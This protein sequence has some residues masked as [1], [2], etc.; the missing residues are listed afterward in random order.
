MTGLARKP[1]A[2]PQLEDGHVRIANELYD[3]IFAFGFKA[4]TLHVLMIVIRKT[5]GYGKKEDDVSASQIGDMCGMKRPHVTAA[6]NE[7]SAMGVIHKRPGKYGAIVGINKN[8]QAWNKVSDST[9]SVQVEVG[10][11]STKTVHPYESRTSTDSVQVYENG[12]SGS[13]KSVQVDSTKFVHTKDN[14]PKDNQQKKETAGAVSSCAELN[15]TP[16]A[17]PPVAT[18]PLADGSEHP[19]T[20][21]MAAEWSAAYPAVDVPSELLRMRAWL[22]ANTANRKTRRG[23]SRF[24]VSWLSR[25]QDRAPVQTRSASRPT[26]A[27][28]RRHEWNQRLS[29]ALGRT[30]EP[31]AV[32]DLGVFDATT[33]KPI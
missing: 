30:N 1:A 19:I 13:T 6:L 23:V 15:S 25:S 3:A 24:V 32:H 21:A 31:N 9:K 28:D 4:S 12:T 10:K 27:A 33:G 2:S 14:L 20:E 17:P 18:L 16:D 11:G 7:L 8:Y 5:Y 29:A 22:N 26:N